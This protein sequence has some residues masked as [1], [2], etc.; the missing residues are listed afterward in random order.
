M[1]QPRIIS[2]G[3]CVAALLAAGCSNMSPNSTANPLGGVAPQGAIGI[4]GITPEWHRHCSG[5]HVFPKVATIK[6][7]QPLHL[8][9]YLL[10]ADL[11]NYTYFYCN[12]SPESARWT[13]SRGT[14]RPLH[15]GTEA[16]FYALRTGVYHVHAKWNGRSAEATVTVISS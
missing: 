12:D 6:V 2:A 3:G 7:S 5:F 15:G 9:A 13:V 14:I 1:K 11:L 8:Y 16:I 4:P 10:Y